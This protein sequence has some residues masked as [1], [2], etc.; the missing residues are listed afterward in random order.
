M[1]EDLSKYKDAFLSEAKEHV[2]SMEK[3]LLNLEKSPAKAEF[4]STIFREAHTLKRMAATMDYGG[5]AKLCHAIEDV[6]DAIKNRKIKPEKCVDV[7]F[8]CFD[9]LQLSLKEIAADAEEIDTQALVQN[10]QTVISQKE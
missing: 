4:L 9:N 2:S 7:L 6:L 3:S 1:S 5:M 8:E 10:L